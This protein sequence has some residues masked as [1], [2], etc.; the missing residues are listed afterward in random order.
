LPKNIDEQHGCLDQSILVRLRDSRVWGAIVGRHLPGELGTVV[1]VS[2]E[3]CFGL[4]TAG[5]EE[6]RGGA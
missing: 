4:N 2:I 5:V 3:C 1:S 6:E